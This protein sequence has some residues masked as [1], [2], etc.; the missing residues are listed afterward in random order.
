MRLCFE[1]GDVGTVLKCIH[2]VDD[3]LTVQ[4]WMRC[5]FLGVCGIG[6]GRHC[7]SLV[8]SKNLHIQ[9][10]SDPSLPV[11]SAATDKYCNKL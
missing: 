6:G 1:P 3:R 8:D 4:L 2:A 9:S 7:G 11:F 5:L 10:G